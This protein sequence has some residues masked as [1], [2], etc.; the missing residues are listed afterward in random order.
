MEET[1][2]DGR[3]AL[4]DKA[5]ARLLAPT[6]ALFLTLQI[7]DIV[8]TNHALR[9]PGIWEANPPMTWA[10][11]KLGAARWLPKLRRGRLSMRRCDLPAP[12]LADRLRGLGLRPLRARQH[13]PFLTPPPPQPIKSSGSSLLAPAC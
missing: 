4:C 1:M 6:S 12:A 10:Q 7:G 13:Q 8:T 11:A 3:P 5:V 2:R 9:I